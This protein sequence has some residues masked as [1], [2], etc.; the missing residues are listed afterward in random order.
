MSLLVSIIV[1]LVIAALLIWVIDQMPMLAG[2]PGQVAKALIVLL[3]VLWIVQRT[4][5]LA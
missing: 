2:V 1:L 5:V 4:G 3:A